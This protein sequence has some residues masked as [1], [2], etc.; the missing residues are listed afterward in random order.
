M[1]QYQ[2]RFYYLILNY[3]KFLEKLNVITDNLG[4]TSTKTVLSN[5]STIKIYIIIIL[6]AHLFLQVIIYFYIHGYFKILSELFNDIEKKM[7]LKNDEIS[8]RDMFLQKIEKLKII[9]S[10]YK[11][12]TYQAIVDLNFIYDNYKKFMEEKNKEMANFLKKEKYSNTNEKILS[13]H[14]K[15]NKEIQKI[16]SSIK[17]NRL[18]LYSLI[19]CS[20]VS[21]A[22]CI[23]LYILW[24]SYELIYNR[25]FYLI[26]SHGNLTND[27]YKVIN[28]YQLML[29]N[30]ITLEDINNFEGF[31]T[32]KGENFFGKLYKDL[33]DL[34]ESKKYMKNL[35]D[36][37]LDN[38]DEYFNHTCSSFYDHLYNTTESFIKSPISINFKSFF[39]E[40]CEIGNVFKSNNYKHI[41]SMLFEMIQLRMNKISDYSYGGLISHIRTYD[42]GKT[43]FV[44][45]LVYYYTL[46]I[47]GNQ[48]QTQSYQKISSLIDLYLHTEFLIY[49]IA[50]FIFILII[51]I[52]YIN[53]FNRNY[54]HLHEMKNVFKI[55]NKRE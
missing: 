28:Y 10:L 2:I 27:A 55:C 47:L 4:K 5:V 17:S 13:S 7:D 24:I 46:Q 40:T 33:E 34:Y 25:I 31:D 9:I 37:N 38:I 49:Y 35:K 23:A 21:I 44:V 18:Y 36:Y 52:V 15:K 14:I 19:F 41:F 42:Y 29:Y 50:S 22:I 20:L 3:Q 32:S 11:Q 53:K 43:I 12:D 54:H 8:V 45:L 48:I 39:I 51:I 6:I 1:T 16:I 30:S 26:E